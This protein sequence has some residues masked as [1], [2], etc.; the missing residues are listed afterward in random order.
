MKKLPK[1]TGMKRY[2]KKN[3]IFLKHTSNIRKIGKKG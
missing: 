3:L 2:L 1:Y